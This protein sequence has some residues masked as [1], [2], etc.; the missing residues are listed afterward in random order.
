MKKRYIIYGL[1]LSVLFVYLL[2]IAFGIMLGGL[3]RSKR[4]GK[5][6]YYLVESVT[7]NVDLSF[8]YPDEREGFYNVVEGHIIN[9]YWNE[10]Y[11]LVTQYYNYEK[12]DSITGYYIIK[13][14]PPVEKGVP[15]ENTKFE[16]KEEYERKKQELGLDEEK[17]KHKNLFDTK[18]KIWGFI[19]LFIVI[20]TLLTIGFYVLRKIYYS[21]KSKDKVVSP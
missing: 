19:K 15:W 10:Q 16:T 17:M 6:N 4:L 5:T 8:Q 1:I 7:P 2:W 20:G 9:A 12:S 18:H 3:T 13:M 11:I 14:L 21:L